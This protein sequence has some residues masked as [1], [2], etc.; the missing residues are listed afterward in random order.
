MISNE[1]NYDYPELRLV[2]KSR[3]RNQ[4]GIYLNLN[5]K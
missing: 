4:Q 5:P 3:I 2:E 1:I